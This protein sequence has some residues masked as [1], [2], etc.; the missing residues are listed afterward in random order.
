MNG[1]DVTWAARPAPLALSGLAASG[2]AATLLLQRLLRCSDEQLARLRG[3]GDRA[4]L[5]VTGE[6]GDLPWVDGVLY[7]GRDENAPNLLLP[8][9]LQP[10][11]PTALLE[12]A[13]MRRVKSGSAPLA[14]LPSPARLVP[15]SVARRLDR[16][17]L[18][19]LAGADAPP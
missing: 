2:P 19:R 9:H 5:V 4:L 17:T 18:S 1:L 6:P 14:V 8:T 7:L 12:L 16:E 10:S 15:L 3:V 11:L 13:L